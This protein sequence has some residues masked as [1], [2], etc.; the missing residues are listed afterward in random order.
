LG[1][2]ANL[3]PRT[4]PPTSPATVPAPATTVVVTLDAPLLLARLDELE[5]VLLREPLFARPFDERE[6]PPDDD[7]LWGL[8]DVLRDDERCLA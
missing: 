5:F 8:R 7:F 1:L 3:L 4:T 6:D 2:R